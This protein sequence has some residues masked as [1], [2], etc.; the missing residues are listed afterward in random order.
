MLKQGELFGSKYIVTKA[1]GRVVAGFLPLLLNQNLYYAFD[2]NHI[3]M[4]Q[5][6]WS[7][8]TQEELDA[9]IEIIDV[10]IESRVSKLEDINEVLTN[11]NK[12]AKKKIKILEDRFIA[13]E[14]FIKRGR[15]TA[16]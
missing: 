13:V 5:D 1:A 12:D 4:P 15:S 10:S 2:D 9:C 16:R 6:S 14:R 8:L 3:L 7:L 11:E